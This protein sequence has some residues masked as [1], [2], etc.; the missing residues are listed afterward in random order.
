MNGEVG[1]LWGWEDKKEGCNMKEYTKNKF[2][3]RDI[4]MIS[5]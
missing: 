1:G 3:S 4:L 2:E 5:V